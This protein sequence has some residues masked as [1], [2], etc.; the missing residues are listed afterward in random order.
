LSHLKKDL[1]DIKNIT[2]P[3]HLKANVL[4]IH[5][6]TKITR[7]VLCRAVNLKVGSR[8]SIFSIME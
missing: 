3:F 5:E 6:H 7:Y 4:N 2:N 1:A 8:L